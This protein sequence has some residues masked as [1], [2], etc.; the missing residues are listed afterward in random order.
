MTDKRQKTKKSAGEKNGLK[1][2]NEP[3]TCA[4]TVL[5][6]ELML[7]L[8]SASGSPHIWQRRL[9]KA[10]SGMRTPTSWAAQRRVKPNVIDIRWK[11]LMHVFI[12]WRV[13]LLKWR[14]W[15]LCSALR[16]FRTQEWRDRA[17][18]HPT[19]PPSPAP[20]S[21][22][23]QDHVEPLFLT[24]DIFSLLLSVFRPGCRHLVV[25]VHLWLAYKI[26]S[27]KI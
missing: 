23:R 27:A 12:F 9:M 14:G 2:S 16:I 6:C 5:V 24:F 4:A 1:M 10:W 25:C 11:T 18:G 21:T 20:Y 3:L 22:W 15:D 13:D 26:P 19:A 17:A 8:V 7:A